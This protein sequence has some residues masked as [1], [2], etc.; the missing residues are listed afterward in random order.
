MKVLIFINP[1]NNQ[2]SILLPFSE[3][4]TLKEIGENDI[5]NNIPFWEVEQNNLPLNVPQEI[6][7]LENMGEPSG[8]GKR[9]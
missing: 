1:E 2:P 6:W 9:K 5:P 3:N 4:L 8:Y 7:K